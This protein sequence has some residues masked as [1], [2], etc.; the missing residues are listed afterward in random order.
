MVGF[1]AFPYDPTLRIVRAEALLK[2]GYPELAAA[3]CYLARQLIRG[4]ED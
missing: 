1:S 3:D 4:F 2:L